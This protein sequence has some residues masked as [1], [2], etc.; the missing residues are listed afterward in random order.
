MFCSK[1]HILCL[2]EK[3]YLQVVLEWAFRHLYA[4]YISDRMILKFS[5]TIFGGIEK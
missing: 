5:H 3:K 1:M 2:I 4:N